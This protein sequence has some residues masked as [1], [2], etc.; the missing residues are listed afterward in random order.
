MITMFI[1]IFFGTVYLLGW[2]TIMILETIVRLF[3]NLFKRLFGL[4]KKDEP[5]VDDDIVEIQA[6]DNGEWGSL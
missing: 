2:L 4:D 1:I 3:I 5:T 6:K